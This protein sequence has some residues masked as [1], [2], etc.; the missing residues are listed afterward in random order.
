MVRYVSVISRDRAVV[1]L[2]PHEARIGACLWNAWDR[3][4]GETQLPV[5]ISNRARANLVYDYAVV[6]ARATLA[7]VEGLSLSESRG[8]LLVAVND[9]LLLR[10]KKYRDGLATSG[11]QTRQQQLFAYQQLTLDG[12][13]PMTQI[14]AG[15]LLDPFQRE[16]E[17]VAITCRIGS[18]L[19]W[20]LDVP[21]PRAGEVVP[22]Q[23]ARE[24]PA[25]KVRST[26][27]REEFGEGDS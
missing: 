6:E 3:Y 21:D 23:T 25:A 24:A 7:G 9:A 18:R 10:F 16:I 5:A 26:L 1:I 27:R 8:F 19:V 14:I 15:Y 22:I 2:A 11:I 13:P 17:R 20:A 4:K 12:M